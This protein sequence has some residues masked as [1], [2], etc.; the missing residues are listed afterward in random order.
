M[1]ATAA[2]AFAASIA[3]AAICSGVTGI[4]GCLPTVSPDPVTAQVTTTSLF[5]AASA[6]STTPTAAMVR[7]RQPRY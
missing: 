7:R 4:A 6:P 1:C 2:P 3:A 5:M